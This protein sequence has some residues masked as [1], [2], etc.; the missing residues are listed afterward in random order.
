MTMRFLPFL[1]IALAAGLAACG[2]GNTTTPSGGASPTVAAIPNPTQASTLLAGPC[3]QLTALLTAEQS[4][5][6]ALRSGAV[7]GQVGEGSI[8]GINGEL[9][10]AVEAYGRSSALGIAI[11]QLV[12][13]NGTLSAALNQ[14]VP[15]ANLGLVFG[16][17]AQDIANIENNCH[18]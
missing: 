1:G 4:A 7:S 16:S 6:Q 15:V 5:I 12:S 3:G 8:T 10:H 13:E 17:I 18:G 14:S 9:A 11:T 2:S